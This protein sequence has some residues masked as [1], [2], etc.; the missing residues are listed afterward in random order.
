[1]ED[2]KN[3]FKIAITCVLIL[4]SP[5]CRIKAQ[6]YLLGVRGGTSFERD[7]G[8]FQQVDV[9]GAKYLPWLWGWDNGLNLRP[10]WGVSAGWLNNEGRDEFVGTTGLALDLCVGKF[11]VTLEAGA[12]FTALSRSQFPD[13][14]LGGLVSIHRGGRSELACYKTMHTR[15]AVSTHVQ[16]RHLQA[17]P[18]L[19]PPNAFVQLF[20]LGLY[21]FCQRIWRASSG[22]EAFGKYGI[23]RGV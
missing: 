4:F 23:M 10:R 15:L 9:F 12:S 14:D 20:I 13:R 17:R 22:I 7:A 1:M 18:G 21:Y 16:R 11:P 3:P 5:L 2:L 8:R 6:D 19:K